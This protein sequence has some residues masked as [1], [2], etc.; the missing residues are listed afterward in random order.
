LRNACG[1]RT[2]VAFRVSGSSRGDQDSSRERVPDGS[3]PGTIGSSPFRHPSFRFAPPRVVGL[4]LVE[5]AVSVPPSSTKVLNRNDRLDHGK[6]PHVDRSPT[7]SDKT[8]R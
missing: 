4:E 3:D 8:T 2:D 6:N 5:S 7:D 1:L